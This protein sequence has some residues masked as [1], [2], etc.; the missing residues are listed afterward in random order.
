MR[1]SAQLSAQSVAVRLHDATVD[2]M[3]G[4]TSDKC[5]KVN[6]PRV[7]ISV[8]LRPIYGLSSPGK[9]EIPPEGIPLI[10]DP[11]RRII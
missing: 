10:G 2:A 9:P 5:S 7:T 1:S 4:I 8:K 3:I 11:C 6:S